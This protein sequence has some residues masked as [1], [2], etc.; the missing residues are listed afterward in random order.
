M[1]AF[2]NANSLSFNDSK[3]LE[4]SFFSKPA[5][6][7]FKK[8]KTKNKIIIAIIP[9]VAL[10]AA[11]IV[12]LMNFSIII[13]PQHKKIPQNNIVDLLN[14]ESVASPELINPHYASK[15]TNNIAYIDLP[16]STKS[17][18]S[19]HL[20]N[21]LDISNSTINLVLRKPR[22]TLKLF[23]ILRDTKFF[24]NSSKPL[25]IQISQ[26]SEEKSYL[27]IPINFANNIDSN[28]SLFRI[29]QIRFI[30]YQEEKK[31]FPLF[32]KNVFLEKNE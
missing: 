22:N 18:F 12:F 8:S 7:S 2:I 14:N 20:K 32:V 16:F 10:S 30:F 17:G 6:K 21:K 29:N 25:V 27:T 11:G 26:N 24:S 13:I 3:R 4:K 15:I 28:V 1:N 31:F 23:L 5:Q 19:L 9:I